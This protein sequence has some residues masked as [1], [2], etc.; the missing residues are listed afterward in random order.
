MKRKKEKNDREFR[1]IKQKEIRGNGKRKGF[2]SINNQSIG[3]ELPFSVNPRQKLALY[4]YACKLFD[5]YLA[6]KKDV[7]RTNEN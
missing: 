2:T 5:R 1:R 3:V 7:R 4:F 6:T